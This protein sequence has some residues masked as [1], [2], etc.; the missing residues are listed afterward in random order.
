[1]ENNKEI[2]NTLNEIKDLMEKSSKF[3]AVSGLSI[4]IVGI[5]GCIAAVCV[6]GLMGAPSHYAE[7]ERA[8][9]YFPTDTPKHL[10]YMI[11]MAGAL[12]VLCLLTVFLMSYFSAKRHQLRFT[13]DKT[14][15]QMLLN[16]FVPMCAGG[17]FCIAIV[18]QHHY[19][20]T[21][22]IMLMFYGLA[23]IN[24]SHYTYS[25]FRYLGYAELV[26]GLIDCFTISN[27]LLFWTIGF[28]LFHIIFGIIYMIK[29]E[30]P[31][32]IAQ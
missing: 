29:F 13:F 1:M 31:K 30:H 20:L 26:L 22:S 5:L 6:Y 27:A 3:K 10:L 7:A 2:I 18:L 9:P 11:C 17:L 25:S 23:L 12:I 32:P 28:G 15:R 14:M 24:M 19:G 8:L 4:V 16:F 21:S